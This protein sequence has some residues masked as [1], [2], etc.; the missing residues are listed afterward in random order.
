MP[1]YVRITYVRS[2]IGR[3][4]RQKRV[5][6]ALGLKRLHHSRI[7]V[8]S[9]SLRGMIGKISHLLEVE[10]VDEKNIKDNLLTAE[11]VTTNSGIDQVETTAEEN[12]TDSET[13]SNA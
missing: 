7:M 5:V 4:Y 10:M 3:S 8:D 12:N 9:A 13:E 11:P 1:D 6:K 2:A